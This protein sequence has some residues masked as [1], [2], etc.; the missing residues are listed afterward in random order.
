MLSGGRDDEP[1]NKR[2]Y[3]GCWTGPM[4]TTS[5]SCQTTKISLAAQSAAEVLNLFTGRGTYNFS[6][7]DQSSCLWPKQIQSKTRTTAALGDV[8]SGSVTTAVRDTTIDG[9]AIHENDNLGMVDGKF[10]C[11]TWRRKPWLKLW[12]ICWTKIVKSWLSMS[13]K[14]EAKNLPNEVLKSRRR[15]EDVEVEIHQGQQPRISYLFSVE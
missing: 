3:Q 8:V 14:T 9:L 6:R 2:L 5:S 15:G 13:V 12:S 7:I 1:F 10:S 4:L 11:Q